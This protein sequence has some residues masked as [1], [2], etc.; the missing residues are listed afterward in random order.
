MNTSRNAAVSAAAVAAAIA[1]AYLTSNHGLLIGIGG[2]GVIGGLV[3]LVTAMVMK[4]RP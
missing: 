2:G 1:A 3:G 4:N